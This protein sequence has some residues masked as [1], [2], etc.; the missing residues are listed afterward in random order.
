MVSLKTRRGTKTI[1][2]K[3]LTGEDAITEYKA[4]S[5][6]VRKLLSDLDKA[7]TRHD[8]RQ[9]TNPMDWGYVGNL[10]HVLEELR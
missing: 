7:L 9:A 2:A 8:K 1:V 4:K 10:G 6:E 5:R 3:G